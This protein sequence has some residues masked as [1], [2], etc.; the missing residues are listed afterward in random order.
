MQVLCPGAGL[1][2]PAERDSFAWTRK[3]LQPLAKLC[4]PVCIYPEG[5]PFNLSTSWGWLFLICTKDCHWSCFTTPHSWPWSESVVIASFA[6][7]GSG[8]SP[9]RQQDPSYSGDH[10][11]LLLSLLPGSDALSGMEQVLDTYL[12]N[13]FY[14]KDGHGDAVMEE[15]PGLGDSREACSK[16]SYS[17]WI[18]GDST[19]KTTWKLADQKTDFTT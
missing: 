2:P 18:N 17:Y 14:K 10:G 11:F 9:T 15:I 8:S 7:L 4:A 19:D 3:T 13:E 1:Y 5:L 12:C 16:L 6:Q